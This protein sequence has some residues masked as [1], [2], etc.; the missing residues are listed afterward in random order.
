MAQARFLGRAKRRSPVAQQHCRINIANGPIGID[1]GTRETRAEKRRTCCRR[2]F[3]QT[4]YESILDPV[5]LLSWN[6]N[7]KVFG[8][9]PTRMR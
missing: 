2:I 4:V 9:F 5:K 1:I 8:I 6:E 3:E 7:L